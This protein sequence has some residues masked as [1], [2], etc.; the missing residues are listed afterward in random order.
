[1]NAYVFYVP[2]WSRQMYYVKLRHDKLY[3]NLLELAWVGRRLFRQG[4]FDR[5]VSLNKMSRDSNVEK[6]TT[7][8]HLLHRD[9]FSHLCWH[10]WRRFLIVFVEGQQ[11]MIWSISWQM[12]RFQCILHMM[13]WRQDH[14]Q[15]HTILMHILVRLVSSRFNSCNGV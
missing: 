15:I 8:N 3:K 12:L 13:F 11:I 6:H 10:A 2:G 1:M 4:G 5:R 14:F 7:C 9:S